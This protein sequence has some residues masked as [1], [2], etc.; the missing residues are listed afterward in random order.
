LQKLGTLTFTDAHGKQQNARVFV[1][2]N[3][4]HGL[5]PGAVVIS[6]GR[7]VYSTPPITKENPVITNYGAPFYRNSEPPV[8]GPAPVTVGQL[9]ANILDK[10]G[11]ADGFR[12]I[13]YSP[14]KSA[15]QAAVCKDQ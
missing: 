7:N 6:T 14:E 15:K 3:K 9:G 1:A 8:S 2:V 10:F 12:P 4:N 13:S 5:Q 11:Q